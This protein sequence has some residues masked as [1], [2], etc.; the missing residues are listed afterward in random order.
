MPQIIVMEMIKKQVVMFA[1]ILKDI[2]GV[3]DPKE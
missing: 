2:F 1:A 3:E